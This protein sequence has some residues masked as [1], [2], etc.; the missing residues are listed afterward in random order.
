MNQS[1]A[2]HRTLPFGSIVRVTNLE[3]PPTDVRIIDRGPLCEA[4]SLTFVRGR[5]RH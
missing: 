5:A 2:A 3:R 1:V 4:A